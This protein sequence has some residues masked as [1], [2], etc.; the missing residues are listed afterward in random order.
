[1]IIATLLK[2]WA[3]VFLILFVVLVLLAFIIRNKKASMGLLIVAFITYFGVIFNTLSNLRFLSDDQLTAVNQSRGLFLTMC[4]LF[5]SLFVFY[6]KLKKI[7]DFKRIVMT[8]LIVLL[9]IFHL[10]IFGPATWFIRHLNQGVEEIPVETV[11][12]IVETSEA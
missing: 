12:I 2:G 5:A 1:M 7:L 6:K 4:L 10:F 3:A 9:V 8:Y 11:E